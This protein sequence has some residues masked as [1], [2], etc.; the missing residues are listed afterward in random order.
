ME[1]VHILA[2][3][4]GMLEVSDYHISNLK[5]QK[6]LYYVYGVNL[7]INPD[8]ELSEGP[9]AWAYGPVFPTV[10]RKFKQYGD[11]TI[12]MPAMIS[13]Y[14]ANGSI[15]VSNISKLWEIIEAVYQRFGALPEFELVRRTHQPGAPW[16]QYYQPGKQKVTIRKPTIKKYFKERVVGEN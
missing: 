1:M 4:N 10:Y 13:P 9:Q 11:E 3:A 6:L 12:T 7:V 15:E 8:E 14:G 5:L 2:A 16:D